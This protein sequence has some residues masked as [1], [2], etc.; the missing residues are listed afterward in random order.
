MLS[1]TEKSRSEYTSQQR[2]SFPSPFSGGWPEGPDYARCERNEKGKRGEKRAY[3]RNQRTARVL[4]MAVLEGEL[5]KGGCFSIRTVLRTGQ[6]QWCVCLLSQTGM[7]WPSG[8]LG[9]WPGRPHWWGG[10]NPWDSSR[11]LQAVRTHWM[12]AGGRPLWEP[13]PY[14]PASPAG[15]RGLCPA[16]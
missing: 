16:G 3:R 10:L 5:V 6:R 13:Y 9:T 8:V 2:P 4:E 11:A 12:E 7:R 1:T 14:F 15:A